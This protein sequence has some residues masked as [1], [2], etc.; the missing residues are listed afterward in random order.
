MLAPQISQK[1]NPAISAKTQEKGFD[2]QLQI[3]NAICEPMQ[4]VA[5]SNV[6]AGHKYFFTTRYSK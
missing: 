4:S 5:K 2:T 6:L 1:N 3:A